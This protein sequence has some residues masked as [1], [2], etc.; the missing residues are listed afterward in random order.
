MLVGLDKPL[1]L[2]RLRTETQPYHRALEQNEFNRALAAGN[3][4]EAIA[5]RFLAKLYGFLRPYEARLRQ[6]AF[7]PAWQPERRQRAHLI[8]QDL[9]AAAH[10]PECADMPELRTWPQLLGALYVLEGSTLG[11]QVITRQLAK[12]G[13]PTRTYFTGS[14]EHTGPLWKSFCQLLAAE[15]TPDNEAEIV[16]SAIQTFQKLHA[17]IELR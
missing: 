4:T 6:H 1:I 9:P 11:G 8:E 14:A 2:Q 13:I 15:A 16:Q 5:A 12:A 17:W 3:I 7:S 10:L